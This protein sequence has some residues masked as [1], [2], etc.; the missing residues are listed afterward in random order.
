MTLAERGIVKIGK[1][2]LP[3][4]RAPPEYADQSSKLKKDNQKILDTP[5]PG[6]YTKLHDWQQGYRNK[7]FNLK[8]I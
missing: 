5:G 3:A 1:N 4:N 6:S 2:L 7:S 8:Y